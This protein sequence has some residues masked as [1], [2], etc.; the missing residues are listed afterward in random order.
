M[1]TIGGVSHLCGL[2]CRKAKEKKKKDRVKEFE[3]RGA[4]NINTILD[5][6]ILKRSGG[7][8]RAGGDATHW[9]MTRVLIIFS[10]DIR[11]GHTRPGHTQGSPQQHENQSTFISMICMSVANLIY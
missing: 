9:R 10:H 4:K 6:M 11:G 3:K 1:A 7:G 2:G 5:T 8:S